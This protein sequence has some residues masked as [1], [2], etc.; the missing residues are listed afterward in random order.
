MNLLDSVSTNIYWVSPGWLPVQLSQ[1]P[2]D[3]DITGLLFY[4][5]FI[6][7]KQALRSSCPM[8]EHPWVAERTS[9]LQISASEDWLSRKWLS[10]GHH[11]VFTWQ[12]SSFTQTVGHLRSGWV[13][14]FT[15]STA[16]WQ[17]VLNCFLS[18]LALLE[19]EWVTASNY[20]FP[21]FAWS[22]PE[23]QKNRV[24]I[25]ISA[26]G[27]LWM[28]LSH[29]TWSKCWAECVQVFLTS[30]RACSFQF[31]S[32]VTTGLLL[33]TVEQGSGRP[34]AWR[35][36]SWAPEHHKFLVPTLPLHWP[37]YCPLRPCAGSL[38]PAT[39]LE[40]VTFHFFWHLRALQSW[41]RCFSEPREHPW[42]R[43]AIHF[44]PIAGQLRRHERDL[45]ST[46]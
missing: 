10:R 21:S 40:K 5:I 23:T 7:R 18:K 45:I 34:W 30:G 39:A 33:A 28:G 11:G 37:K 26:S 35:A 17:V 3:L 15:A 43:R 38:K 13:M 12:G 36:E 4:F 46:D 29:V 31:M 14:S 44:Q 25:G 42:S 22:Y 8:S 16:C 6:R 1:M 9:K 20:S 2:W 24:S 27:W 41:G 19:N 32:V